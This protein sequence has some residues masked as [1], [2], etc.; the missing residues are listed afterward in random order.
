MRHSSHLAISLDAL[1][2]NGCSEAILQ[3]AISIVCPALET[4][5]VAPLTLEE[6]DSRNFNRRSARKATKLR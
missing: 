3:L 1:G 5:K 6:Y 4:T 2:P